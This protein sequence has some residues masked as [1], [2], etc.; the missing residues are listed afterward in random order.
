MSLTEN[1]APTLRK[2]L[3]TIKEVEHITSL[4]STKVFE[5]LKRGRLERVHIG[6]AS[7]V[8][9]ESLERFLADLPRTQQQ[10]AA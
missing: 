6:S 1:H 8:T 9:A 4:G 3:Y 5:L 7:R 2:R 10:G